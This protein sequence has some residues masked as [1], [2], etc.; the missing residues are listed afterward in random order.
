MTSQVKLKF[1]GITSD[2]CYN[3]HIKGDED[4]KHIMI[5][6][7]PI[8]I[9]NGDTVE[10]VIKLNNVYDKL[11]PFFGSGDVEIYKYGGEN[12][13]SCCL[14]KVYQTFALGNLIAKIKVR[15]MLSGAN[16]Y[17]VVHKFKSKEHTIITEQQIFILEKSE[18]TIS[19]KRLEELERI[20][21][22]S[23]K[24]IENVHPYVNESGVI[25]HGLGN[26]AKFLIDVED[27]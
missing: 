15:G 20:E 11:V 25:T 10:L 3:T 5:N 2:R 22:A 1:Y 6:N 12:V 18:V 24:L 7:D 13:T 23:K 17:F 19:T 27:L 26:W 4:M 16:S 8:F 21:K 9:E 14:D